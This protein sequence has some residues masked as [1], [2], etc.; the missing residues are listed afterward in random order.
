MSYVKDSSG[1]WVPQSRSG[2][3]PTPAQAQPPAPA[4]RGHG[5]RQGGG[6]PLV[7]PAQ[8]EPAGRAISTRVKLPRATT[9]ASEVVALLAIRDANK[10]TKLDDQLKTAG[11]GCTSGR[12][13][14][15]GS[16][17]R[18]WAA[19]GTTSNGRAPGTSQSGFRAP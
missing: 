17:P 18:S 10:G 19:T 7:V 14:G 9:T 6:S 16:S 4:P 5:R 12:A 8:G 11:R 3:P 1:K 13:P 15:T 2:A